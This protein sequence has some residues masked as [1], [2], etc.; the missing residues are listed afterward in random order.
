MEGL[1]M[2]LFSFVDFF[3]PSGRHGC[4]PLACPERFVCEFFVRLLMSK[5]A[6]AAAAADI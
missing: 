1:S 4:T 3:F 6:A 5:A 2:T